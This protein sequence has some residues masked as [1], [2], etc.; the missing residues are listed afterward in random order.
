[1]KDAFRIV[2][3]SVLDDGTLPVFAYNKKFV[4]TAE[5][6][7]EAKLHI[8][9]KHPDEIFDVVQVVG[10]YTGQVTPVELEDSYTRRK[11]DESA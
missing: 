4:F 5:E 2:G 9:Q 8:I 3:T 11:S 10:T 7:E 1:M 6:L